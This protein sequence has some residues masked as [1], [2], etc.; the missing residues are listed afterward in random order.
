MPYQF[1][2]KRKSWIVNK[3]LENFKKRLININ[4]T[5]MKKVEEAKG[6]SEEEKNDKN[7]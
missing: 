2:L 3:S 4:K 6:V 7:L 5:S 1:I